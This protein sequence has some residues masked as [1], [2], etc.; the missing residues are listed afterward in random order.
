MTDTFDDSMA[1]TKL[2]LAYKT[3]LINIFDDHML[4]INIFNDSTA[5]T[6][7]FDISP[8]IT[9]ICSR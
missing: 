2:F 4:M 8:T 3:A 1:M 9:E 5:I 6:D 7:I